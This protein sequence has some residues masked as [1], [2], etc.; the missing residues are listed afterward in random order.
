MS[1][2]HDINVAIRRQTD[3]NRDVPQ[4]YGVE[5]NFFMQVGATNSVMGN[6]EYEI[7]ASPRTIYNHKHVTR[8][9][10]YHDAVF[11]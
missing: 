7:E 9:T 3:S 6:I 4:L 10:F 11:Q 1:I 5:K 8:K 2:S